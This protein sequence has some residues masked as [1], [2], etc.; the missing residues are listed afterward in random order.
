MVLVKRI[1]KSFTT[2]IQ[3]LLEKEV[4]KVVAELSKYIWELIKNN[5]NH[6]FKW[7]TQ[8]QVVLEGM[9]LRNW[10]S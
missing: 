6:N 5:T 3:L 8:T 9:K 10:L 1:S 2:T 4:K 7:A